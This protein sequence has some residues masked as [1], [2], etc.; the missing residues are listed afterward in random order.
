MID[1]ASG[2]VT[3][4]EPAVPTT[5]VDASEGW[6]VAVGADGRARRY[7]SAGH[8]VVELP[9]GTDARDAAIG[10][11]A[12]QV[13]IAGG[14]G[15]IHLV[16]LGS[17]AELAVLRPIEITGAALAVDW[18]PDGSQVVAGFEDGA[19]R[20]WDATSGEQLVTYRIDPSEVLDVA[21]TDGGVI[22]ATVRQSSVVDVFRCEVCGTTD[23]VIALARERV[24]RALTAEE[25]VTYL[26][27]APVASASPVPVESASPGPDLASPA[28][29]DAGAS[30]P[31]PAA[32]DDLGLHL[33]PLDETCPLA[34]GRYHPEPFEIGLTFDLGEGWN[35]IG[36]FPTVATIGHRTGTSIDLVT[37][38][39]DG[40]RGGDVV[41]IAPGAAAIEAHMRSIP[42]LSITPSR[43]TMV[44]GRPATTFDITCTC[45]TEAVKMFQIQGITYVVAPGEHDRWTILEVDG[46]ALMINAWAPSDAEFQQGIPVAQ[47]VIDSITF[48]TERGG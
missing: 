43:P 39:R 3:M 10:P 17:T 34:A 32:S 46:E 40:F 48:V 38:V 44:G 8:D 13:A 36:S 5:Q 29:S 24:T 16:D 33:C 15:F 21:A 18:T 27:E 6:I 31:S 30:S 41:P 14:D 25:R 12:T 11:G 42:G 19:I 28:P 20:V 37:A 47:A 22:A 9:L 23:E 35:G 4:L 2:A 7:T 45:Q 26:H 1:V